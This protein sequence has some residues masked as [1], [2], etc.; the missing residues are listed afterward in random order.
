VLSV[1]D[2]AKVR[3]ALFTRRTG[4]GLVAALA[5]LGLL[6]AGQRLGWHRLTRA[7]DLVGDALA[8]AARVVLDSGWLL[9]LLTAVGLALGLAL[10]KTQRRGRL[11]VARRLRPLLTTRPV[12]WGVTAAGLLVLLALVVVVVVILP[13]RFTAHRYFDA[14]ADELKAQNDVR[15]TLLQA[16]AGGVLVVG[17]YFTYRQLRVTREGQITDRYTRAVDQ[18]GS[19]YLDVRLGGIYALERIARDSPHDRATIEEVLSAYVRGHA[20][21]PP[22]LSAPAQSA[23]AQQPSTATAPQP[24]ATAPPAASTD[25]AGQAGERGA[26]P[27][28]PEAD[29]RAAIAVLGRRRLPPDGVRLL[30]LTRVDLRRAPLRGANL[31]YARLDGANLQGAELVLANLRRARLDGAN[32]QS[33]EL[34]GANL[35][36]A[37]LDD[38]DLQGAQLGD[39]NLQHARLVHAN[40]QRAQLAGANLQSAGLGGADL[41]GA[42]FNRA[43]L[44]DTHLGD[45]NLRDAQ[46]AGADLQ[47]AQLGG[48]DLQR[49][50]LGG[51]DLQRAQFTNANL[52]DAQLAF[53]KLQGAQLIGAKLQGAQ[54]RGAKLQDALLGGAKLQDAQLGGANLQ[55]AWLFDADL[56]GARAD[57]HTRWPGWSRAEA[58]ARGVRYSD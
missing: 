16:L 54:L 42:V 23:G 34:D 7:A 17:A 3:R 36:E 49:A 35:Q 18:L 40:L 10:N 57:E 4:W 50:H 2:W 38:A 31:Q 12:R 1:W 48:A 53:A 51:A 27:L 32:L 14:A 43:N 37:W 19:K 21:W 33:A 30:D 45:A 55:D 13:P 44:R 39:A 29:V 56:E 6:L 52:Q 46:L 11:V 15:A 25:T 41:Q 9:L 22:A 20:P 5:L 28:G 24:L 58:E 8:Q 47:R 26:E